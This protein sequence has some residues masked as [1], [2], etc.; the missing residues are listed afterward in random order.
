MAMGKVINRP[1]ILSG[2]IQIAGYVLHRIQNI[3]IGKFQFGRTVA[4]WVSR[5]VVW[6]GLNHYMNNIQCILRGRLT[7]T[8]C[9][10]QK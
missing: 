6:Q 1:K 3:V 10:I 5:I 8:V 9:D 2:D 7:M 4:Y